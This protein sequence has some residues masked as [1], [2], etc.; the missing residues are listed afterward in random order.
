L[1]A[2]KIWIEFAQ[3]A[4][5][6]RGIDAA[7]AI[8]ERAITA[9]GLD[10][11]AG[12]TVW[13]EWRKMERSLGSKN[14]DRVHMLFGRQLS[15]PMTAMESTLEE[16]R[17]FATENGFAA[18]EY[19]STYE[20]AHA[21]LVEREPYETAIGFGSVVLEDP[22]LHYLSFEISHGD[23]ARIRTLYER[24]VAACCLSPTLWTD[25]I[26]WTSSVSSSAAVEVAQRAV[27]NVTS[28][29]VAWATLLRVL[30]ADNRS[31]DEIAAVFRKAEQTDL[32]APGEFV[33][34][35]IAFA[36]ILRRA[37]SAEASTHVLEL[38]TDTLTRGASYVDERMLL[39]MD[40]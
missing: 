31:L 4:Q 22:W 23:A 25:Y 1:T 34:I 2:P 24:A 12:G 36:E 35:F 40:I 8:F 37:Y 9:V 29:G 14:K 5:R 10:I 7:R 20:K 19:D 27:R 32:V 6:S 33:Q 16:Y 26:K 13:N 39:R 28:Y 21:A 30:D 11:A 15:V 38:L 3:H 17:N 18:D